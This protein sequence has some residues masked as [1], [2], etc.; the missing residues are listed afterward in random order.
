MKY[1]N[2]D[3]KYLKEINKTAE[4]TKYFSDDPIHSIIPQSNNKSSALPM[5]LN[6]LN[7]EIQFD[8]VLPIM[9]LQSKNFKDFLYSDQLYGKI[10]TNNDIVNINEQELKSLS[11]KQTL[12]LVAP[13]ADAFNELFVRHKNLL[14]KQV[15]DSKS[16]FADIAPQKAFI[17]PNLQH[18]EYLNLYFNNF[19]NFINSNDLNKKITDFHSFIKYFIVFYNTREKIINRTTF[20]KTKTCSPLATG[21]V[22]EIADQKHGDDKQVYTK[23]IQDPSFPIFD[24]LTK[25]YGF[26]MDKH[27]PW[28]LIFDIAGANA[29]PYLLR[30]NISSTEEYFNQFYYY[31]DY[32]NYENLKI[33]LLNLYNFIVKEKPIFKDI[34]TKSINGKVCISKV[35]IERNF[36]VYDD[37]FQNIAEEDMLKIYAYTICCENN[38]ISTQTQFET[39]FAEMMT[40]K[41]YFNDFEAFDFLNNKRKELS[42]TGTNT[43]TKSFF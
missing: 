38:M 22:V 20:I 4:E 31:T 32:F 29:Q 40:I 42:N 16:V 34:K 10:N 18:N 3:N 36:I 8:R 24:T 6:R 41:R 21:L 28:R 7:Y 23:Y 43:F 30:Y 27:S 17:S 2:T 35:L 13:A 19:Y 11:A 12:S 15:I 33:N 1:K 26:V 14:D 39:L 25:Q 9:S 5:Y 37:L